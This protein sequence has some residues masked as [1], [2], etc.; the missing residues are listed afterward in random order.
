MEH[1]HDFSIFEIME[2]VR[3][4]TLDDVIRR[5]AELLVEPEDYLY[6]TSTGNKFWNE[7]DFREYVDQILNK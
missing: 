1:R 3:N 2:Q 4:T 7:K 5:Y 6:D